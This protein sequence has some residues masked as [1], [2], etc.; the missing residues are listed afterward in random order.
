MTTRELFV[1]KLK[2]A[3]GKP[4]IYGANG[5]DSFDCSGLII[6]G[7]RGAEVAIN[8]TS[9]EGLYNLYHSN[10]ILPSLCKPGDLFFY[11][12][13]ANEVTHVMACCE[14]WE[15]KR[16][17]FDYFTLIGARGGSSD[18]TSNWEAWTKSAMVSVV[19]GSYWKDGFIACCNI[20]KGD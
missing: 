19:L 5:P 18:T 4:Y 16:D 9:A 1:S 15:K 17:G 20:F 6:W 11:G 3:V 8:D 13:K 7:L 14:V 10:K 2:S 12:N